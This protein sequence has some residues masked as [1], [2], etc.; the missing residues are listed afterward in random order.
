MPCRLAPIDHVSEEKARFHTG[1]S[2]LRRPAQ[3]PLNVR[4][5]FYSE[6]ATYLPR[7]TIAD[8]DVEVRGPQ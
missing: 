5:K 1:V 2:I 4:R 8:N 6:Y 7:V 3:G